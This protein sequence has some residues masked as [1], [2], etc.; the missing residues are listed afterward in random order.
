MHHPHDR[1]FRKA[2]GK[3]IVTKDFLINRLPPDIRAMVDLNSLELQPSSFIDE[4]LRPYYADIVFKAKIK[5]KEGY[6]FFLLEHQTNPDHF[7]PVRTLEYSV[8]T[9]R[10]DVEQ[11]L[12]RGVKKKDL[13]LPVVITIVIYAGKKPYPY[14]KR[15]V[16]A[17]QT[18]ELLYK[19]FCED[20]VLDLSK[21]STASIMKDGQGALAELLLK[22]GHR[23]NLGQFL[24][25][26]THIGE[27]LH[28][29][30]Y[31]DPAIMYILDRD[32]RNVDRIL[33]KCTTF[34]PKIKD[35]FTSGLQRL[36][37]S[38]LQKGKKEREKEIAKQMH[39][40]GFGNGIIADL[41]GL[42]LQELK[43]VLS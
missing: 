39:T 25:E 5:G 29:C 1:L 16:D 38:N 7:M 6:L 4:K 14:P 28:T 33:E 21:E 22:E 2:F 31:A 42:S 17:F 36:I 19:M 34:D 40:K 26:N 41:T 3:K 10:H 37:N 30:D 43:K 18:P 8:G 32:R 11:Q 24:T 23:K 20:F 13:R 9:M 15:L 27:L 12:A 35:M